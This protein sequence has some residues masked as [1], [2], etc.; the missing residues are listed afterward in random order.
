MTRFGI[1]ATAR[2]SLALYNNH[3]DVDALIDSLAK[4]NAL[5]G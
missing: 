4:V 2:V 1:S 3:E 5:F